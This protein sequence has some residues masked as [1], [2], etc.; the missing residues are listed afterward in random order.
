MADFKQVPIDPKKVEDALVAYGVTTL[1]VREATAKEKHFSGSHDGKALRMKLF[2]NKDGSCSLGRFT[3]DAEEPFEALAEHVCKTCSWGEKPRLEYSLQKQSHAVLAGLVSALEAKGANVSERKLEKYA[4]T[5][6]VRGPSGDQ[7]TVKLHGNGTLQLQGTHAQLGAWAV[8]QLQGAMGLNEMLAEQRKVYELP[9][10]VQQVR[11]ELVARIPHVHD[12]LVD[13]VR[14]QFSSAHAMTK[15]FIPLEDYAGV[16]FPA[17]RG[18][19]GFCMQLLTDDCHLNP[20][21]IAKLSQYFE[22]VVGAPGQFKMKSPASDGVANILQKLLSDCYTTW[23]KQRHRLFHM[24]GSVETSRIIED[25]EDAVSLVEEVFHLI[26]TGYADLLK[27][28]P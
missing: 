4:E 26:D 20:P 13:E 15:V 8:D 18:L 22:P 1:V 3:G 25:R 21:Q 9:L 2:V 14:K 16:A 28:S 19:E 24:D 5:V 7:L 11:D 10:T 6:K 12:K 17:L 23:D 27:N